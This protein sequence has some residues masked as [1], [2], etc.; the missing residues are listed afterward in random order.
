MKELKL[1]KRCELKGYKYFKAYEFL[2]RFEGLCSIHVRQPSASASRARGAKRTGSPSISQQE[3]VVL[4]IKYF[5]DFLFPISLGRFN[6][7]LRLAH[8]GT[9]HF[10]RHLLC[11]FIFRGPYSRL[12]LIT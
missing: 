11:Q 8:L 10:R 4:V 6:A 5:V 1:I 9:R 2:P 12:V 7:L 3:L